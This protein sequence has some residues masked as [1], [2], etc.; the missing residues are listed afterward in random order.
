MAKI[1][2]SNAVYR[3]KAFTLL[4]SLLV[5]FISTFVLLIFSSSIKQS[6]RTVRAEIFVLQFERLYKDTQYIAGLKGESQT[7]TS[8]QGRLY[9]QEERLLVPKEVEINDFSVTFDKNAGNSSLQ[10]I[11]L[12]LP[13]QKKTISYQLGIGSG[14]YKKTIS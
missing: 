11:T 13:Y 10:K 6:L 12:H 3:I 5:L 7:L 4:E 1:Q 8:T 9:S 14:K 2:I